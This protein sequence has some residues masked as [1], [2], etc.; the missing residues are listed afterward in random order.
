MAEMSREELTRTC[1]DILEHGHG[2][3][4]WERDFIEA[5]LQALEYQQQI[6]ESQAEKVEEIYEQRVT[7]TKGLSR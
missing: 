1:E 5:R 6:T 3:T 2:V 4:K 7:W